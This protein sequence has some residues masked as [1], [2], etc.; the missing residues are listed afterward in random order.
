MYPGYRGIQIVFLRGAL[1][2]GITLVSLRSLIR[3]RRFYVVRVKMMSGRLKNGEKII[4]IQTHMSFSKF[5]TLKNNK[6][7]P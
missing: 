4:E 7:K 1:F 6:R 2:Q 3:A 5:R